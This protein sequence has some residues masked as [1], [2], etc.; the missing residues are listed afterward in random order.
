MA[1]G[2]LGGCSARPPRRPRPH[3]P[4]CAGRRCRLR[5]LALRRL[6]S[7]AADCCPPAAACLAQVEDYLEK[8]GREELLG[9]AVGG[10]PDADLFFVDK[11]SRLGLGGWG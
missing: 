5:L 9:L 8:K 1:S 6:R 11:A 2:L 10:V 4:A 3:A 7:A